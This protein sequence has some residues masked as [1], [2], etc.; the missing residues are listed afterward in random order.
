MSF[1]YQCLRASETN[2]CVHSVIIASGLRIYY[3]LG[4]DLMDMT[5]SYQGVGLWTAVEI[6]VAIISACLPLIR[7]TLRF[8]IPSFVISYV[9]RSRSTQDA[10][11]R[12]GDSSEGR[13]TRSKP[14]IFHS[15][16]DYKRLVA[17]P[18]KVLTSKYTSG[19][20]PGGNDNV[21]GM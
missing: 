11:D 20:E 10:E 4:M 19:A 14:S 3:L 21:G 13:S 5:W 9:S 12:T 16:G 15:Q 17:Y 1:A 8:L 7:P 6:D 2:I 18:M